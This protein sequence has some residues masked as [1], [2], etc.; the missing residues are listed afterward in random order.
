MRKFLLIICLLGNLSAW[1][2]RTISGTLVDEQGNPLAGI[3]ITIIGS[4]EGSISDINGNYRITIPDD[5]V[6]LVF[7][8]EG[9]GR[10]EV[11]PGSQSV[12]DLQM[13]A[14]SIEGT[15]NLSVGYG[16]QTK[17]AITGNVSQVSGEAIRDNPV[18]NLEGSLQGRTPGVV[19][20]STG[21]QVRGS[22]SLVA[23]NDPLYVV[24]GV[25]LASGSQSKINPANIKSIEILKDASAAAIYGSRAANG[26]IVI[27]TH[28]GRSG[29]MQIDADYQIGVATTPKY[30]DLYTPDDYNRQVIEYRIRQAGLGEYVDESNLYI[31]QQI[32]ESQLGLPLEERNPLIVGNVAF[33]NIGAFYDSLQYN[34]DWQKRVFQ[35]ALQHRATISFQGGSEKLG[36]Y[37]SNVFSNQEGILIGQQNKTINSLVSLDSKITSKLRASLS[38]NFIHNIQDKLREDQD[39]GAPLQAIAL[40][41]SDRALPS[42]NYYLSVNKLLYNP[43]TEVFNSINR[44][45]SNAWIGSLGLNYQLTENLSVDLAAGIDYSD[46]RDILQLGGETRDG[47]GTYQANGSGRSQLSLSTFKNQ[48]LN[49]W[50]TYKPEIGERSSLSVV[51]GSSYEKST[52]EFDI[53]AANVATI[54]ELESLDTGNPL[55]QV[56]NVQGGAS[57]F[58]SAFSRI[59]Y[60]FKDRY[61]IQVTGRRDGSS[62][63]AIDNRFGTFLAVS[64]GWILSD[65][66]FF[67]NDGLIKFLKLKASYGQI[68]N[69]PLEDFAYQKNYILV[70]YG[71]N[72]GVKLLNPANDNLKWETTSQTNIGMEF[73]VG[74]RVTGSLDYYAK[75]TDDLLFPKSVS[76]TSGFTQ[77]TRNG[78]SLKNTGVEIGL[79]IR[80]I[81]Q[82]DL[83]WSTDFNIT[84]AQNRITNLNGERLV[85]GTNAF[86]EGYPASSFYL[87]KYMGVN[88]DTGEAEY[89][90]GTGNPTTDWES[91][92]RMIVGNPNPGYYGGITNTI[93]YKAFELSFMVQFVGDVDRYFATGEYLANSGILGLSQMASQTERWYAPGD[94]A[95]Y[96]ALDPFTTDTEPSTRWLEDG[97]YA[98][99]TNLILTY[100]LP[101]AIVERWGLQRAQVYV[102]GQN[103]LTVSNYSGYD[104][105]VVY[106]DPTTGTLGQNLNRGVD[107]FTAPQARIITTGIKIGL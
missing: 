80:N 13:I 21:V 52:S 96:P 12:I 75:V 89:D 84:F 34:T 3:S 42:N 72:Q 56:T 76:P 36:Y 1:A 51:L 7:S 79:G 6:T 9:F 44:S 10:Q 48:L 92:P 106:I 26:V 20:K 27:T 59:N 68:G 102:G 50:L 77:V 87:R 97:S 103:L 40:P 69:T 17:E 60:A 93:S 85:A 66:P 32:I 95:K 55:L 25:P 35:T 41:P 71:D 107:N 91:A 70:N 101:A 65:E 8:G 39:L 22:A 67:N 23:G 31:W 57:V 37:V 4:S 88:E 83:K 104:P 2:Q 15:S 53:T 100:N 81:D 61:L 11:Q 64:G 49:G 38:M 98:R 63:F 90:D 30:L 99:L 46:Y 5:Y 54:S 105:D 58:V 82:P 47:G 16:G 78:G 86:I 14:V 74:S 73:S 24:D 43:E 19:V 18:S 94:K 62:K 29:K 28:S 45:T 33:A